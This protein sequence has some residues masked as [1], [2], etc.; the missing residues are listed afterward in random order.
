[1]IDLRMLLKLAFIM[2]ALKS[3][4]SLNHVRYKTNR[5]YGTLLS[6]SSTSRPETE[7]FVEKK[8]YKRFMQVEC[9]YRIPE[10]ASLYPILCSLELACRDINRLMRRVATDK[11]DGYHSNKGSVGTTTTN[12]QGEDQKK[13]DVIANRI[14]KI[15][16]CC[17]GNLQ[18]VASE[19]EDEACLCSDVADN[20]AFNGEY[21]AVFDP[22]DGSSNIGKSP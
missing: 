9:Q 21:A 4:I 1:M 14:M 16:L 17:S 22:L 6:M 7:N 15:T 18:S 11:L 19:E 20:A 10:F 12:I 8:S 3:L 5:L 2:T 13:L